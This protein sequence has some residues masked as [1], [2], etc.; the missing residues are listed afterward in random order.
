[1]SRS[2]RSTEGGFTADFEV[3]TAGQAARHSAGR[4]TIGSKQ[5]VQHCRRQERW[6]QPAHDVRLE[7]LQIATHSPYVDA[8]HFRAAIEGRINVDCRHRSDPA[9]GQSISNVRSKSA[10]Q[11]W[12][13]EAI[14]NF[15]EAG[16]DWLW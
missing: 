3:E 8:S 4:R 16:F 12:R 13:Y 7:F 2:G 15:D 1:M 11:I 10:N 14:K 5:S 9:C 6:D